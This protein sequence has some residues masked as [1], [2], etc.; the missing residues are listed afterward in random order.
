MHVIGVKL[1]HNPPEYLLKLLARARE[2]G[3]DISLHQLEGIYMAD[4]NV[5][6]IVEYAIRM[7]SCGMPLAIQRIAEL[8]L[9]GHD[10]RTMWEQKID[11]SE[12]EIDEDTK[13]KANKFIHLIGVSQSLQFNR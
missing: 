10:L 3:I 4:G 9:A 6:D 5:R 11:P 12:I 2:G 1:R 8:D 13:Q 7:S